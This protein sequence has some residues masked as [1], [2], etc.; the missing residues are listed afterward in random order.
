MC[1]ELGAREAASY[2]LH[3]PSLH[4][5]E[6]RAAGPPAVRSVPT[7][8]NFECWLEFPLAILSVPT[9]KKKFKGWVEF[10]PEA[11]AA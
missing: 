10:P 7:N 4:Q 1:R 2:K 8:K 5:H 6:L 3:A 9:N 11:D